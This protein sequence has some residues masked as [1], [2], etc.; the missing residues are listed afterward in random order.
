MYIVLVGPSGVRK[1]SAMGPA[2]DFLVDLNVKLAAEAITREALIKELEKAN[3]NDPNVATGEMYFHSSLTI[4]SPELTVFL[5]YNNEQLM[6]DLTDWYDCRNKWTYRTKNM[7]TNEIHG[8]YVNLIGATTP[9]L[10]KNTMS[11]RAI[12]GGLTSRM[13]FVYEEE[14]GPA[15]PAPFFNNGYRGLRDQLAMDLERIYML[16]GK[17]DITKEFMDLWTDWYLKQRANPPFSDKIKWGGYMKRRPNHIMKLCMILNA[18][19]SDRMILEKS[20]LERSINLLAKTEA[21]ME[22]TF[23]GVGKYTHAET[24][25]QVMTE[26]GLRGE[27]GISS[28][29]LTFLFRNDANRIIMREIID[30]LN[31]MGWLDVVTKEGKDVYKMRERSDA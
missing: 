10:I 13:I 6:S 22:S 9:D 25:T 31:Q 8:V 24:L 17:F 21:N 26:I 12:G 18:S 14:E 7:G 20:D 5:G 23:S 19:R 29:D 11:L 1:G 28:E 30:T 27:E 2:L 3:S 4:F 16:S 15:C